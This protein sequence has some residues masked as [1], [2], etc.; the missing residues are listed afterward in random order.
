ML[1]ELFQKT[2]AF[3]W[4]WEDLVFLMFLAALKLPVPLWNLNKSVHAKTKL[5]YIITR[6]FKGNNKL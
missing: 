4:N 3:S 1:G 2:R 5:S 6:I